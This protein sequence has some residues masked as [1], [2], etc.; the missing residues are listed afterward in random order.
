MDHRSEYLLKQIQTGEIESMQVGLAGVAARWMAAG[1]VDQANRLLTLWFEVSDALTE[2]PGADDDPRQRGDTPYH[3]HPPA[4]NDFE[5]PWALTGTRPDCAAVPAPSFEDV[6]NALWRSLFSP[7]HAEEYVERIKSTPLDKLSPIDLWVRAKTLAYDESRPGRAAS[8]DRLVEALALLDASG[9]ITFSRY[10][11]GMCQAVLAARLGDEERVRKCL[12]NL[13]QIDNNRSPTLMNRTITRIALSG[14]LAPVLRITPQ[15]C[16]EDARAIQDAW[17]ERRKIGRFVHGLLS[18]AQLLRD[19]GQTCDIKF[20]RKR[21]AATAIKAAEKRLGVALPESYRAFLKVK[22]GL[23][24][25]DWAGVEI[26]P[27]AQ[28]A[29]LRDADKDLIDACSSY[30]ELGDISRKLRASLLI[31]SEPEGSERLLLVPADDQAAEW[32]CWFYAHWT[33]P[34]IRHR[35]FRAFIESQLQGRPT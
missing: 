16:D 5:I 1:C 33:P 27:V 2:L 9:P 30:P 10:D 7:V 8:R 17:R 15:A 19:L 22:N 6:E 20:K 23:E 12:I 32:E 3:R 26:L 14:A 34:P 35:T 29:W 25:Y 28:I 4:L 24:K 13:A 11:A 31:G 18:W 21:A